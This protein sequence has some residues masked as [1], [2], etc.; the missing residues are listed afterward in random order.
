MKRRDKKQPLAKGAVFFG[1]RIGKLQFIGVFHG[2]K[3][4]INYALREPSPRG[5]GGG[6]P[7]DEGAISLAPQPL[8]TASAE[9]SRCGSVTLGV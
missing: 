5:E 6:L 1:V 4:L 9:P 3:F 2:I 8:T 7:T